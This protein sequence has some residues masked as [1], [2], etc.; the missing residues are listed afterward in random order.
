MS[1]QLPAARG[2]EHE[3]PAPSLTVTFPLGEPAPG[4]TTETEKLTVTGW[5]TTD[6]LGLRLDTDTLVSALLTCCDAEAED[7]LKFA[8]PP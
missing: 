4:A 1:E 3:A 7:P 5:P 6:A 2:A 8:F